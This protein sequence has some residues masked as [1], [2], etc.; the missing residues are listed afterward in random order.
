MNPYCDKP[1]CLPGG[2]NPRFGVPLG[3]YEDDD[4]EP[5]GMRYVSHEFDETNHPSM[6]ERDR[7]REERQ[8]ND[9]EHIKAHGDVV[10]HGTNQHHAE[11][12]LKDGFHLDNMTNGRHAGHGVYT[13]TSF[14]EAA[15]YGTHVVEAR[16][17]RDDHHQDPW[18]DEEV[19]EHPSGLGKHA[20]TVHHIIRGM[21]YIGHV[22]TDDPGTHVTYNPKHVVPVGL[23]MGSGKH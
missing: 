20:E 22:D 17:L 18:R 3:H 13:T 2:Y 7:L 21:G 9:P 1:E 8:Q 15:K 4:D 12:I 11:S 14:R 16:I 19:H 6:S 23:H 5:H 10:Y